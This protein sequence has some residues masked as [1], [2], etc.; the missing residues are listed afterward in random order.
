MNNPDHLHRLSDRSAFCVPPLCGT[1]PFFEKSRSAF[2]LIEVVLAIGVLSFSFL[3]LFNMI[4]VGLGMMSSSIDSTVGM[5][6]VQRVT[7]LA[8]Q[9]KFSELAKL[10][11]NS[12]TDARGEK[13]DFFFDDQ[14][15]EVD[16]QA[17]TEKRYV[18][19]AAVVLLKVKD[20]TQKEVVGSTVP[21]RTGPQSPNPDLLSIKQL[22]T[23][24]IATIYI[25]IKKNEGTEVVRTV[26]VLI[27]NN[28][29]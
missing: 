14:G 4:P 29:L 10:D 1:G 12:G 26:N 11:K 16:A 20:E 2:S 6:I 13:S 19:S 28:G 3:V 24:N 5:Q 17:V 23:T 25:I 21:G 15:N 22:P 18:Y 27:A 8:R 9:A 7:T